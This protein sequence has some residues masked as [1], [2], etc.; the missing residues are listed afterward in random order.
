MNS[1]NLLNGKRW[2]NGVSGNPKGRPKKQ[3][4]SPDVVDSL[5]ADAKKIQKIG[6]TP[7]LDLLTYK[8]IGRRLFGHQRDQAIKAIESSGINLSRRANLP[9]TGIS[10]CDTS[11]NGRPISSKLLNQLVE[12]AKNIV[13]SGGR[14][15]VRDLIVKHFGSRVSDKFEK[16]IRKE[17]LERGIDVGRRAKV[18]APT[19]VTD[20]LAF[21]DDSQTPT[22][23][24]IPGTLGGIAADDSD[25]IDVSFTLGDELTHD[26]D[27][28]LAEEV[29]NGNRRALRLLKSQIR[30][31]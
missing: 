21:K 31:G 4:L 27:E 16:T 19:V 15:R 17:L 10:A 28:F 5:V 20:Q 22:S 13:D 9:I 12:E 6:A 1:Q 14:A 25:V 11:I 7:S 23:E 3:L 24:S 26:M 30:R 8:R 29:R 2:P 18:H